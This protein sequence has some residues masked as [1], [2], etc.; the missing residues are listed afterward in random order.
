MET[1]WNAYLLLPCS[2]PLA[3]APTHYQQ[4]KVFKL[5]YKASMIRHPLTSPTSCLITPW[6]KLHYPVTV[7][8]SF[9]FVIYHVI[10]HF[11]FFAHSLLWLKCPFSFYTIFSTYF[12]GLLKDLFDP[13]QSRFPSLMFFSSILYFI[14]PLT[15]IIVYVYD[16]ISPLQFSLEFE[17]FECRGYLLFI[18]I[19]TAPVLN[20]F[21]SLIIWKQNLW[22]PTSLI[23]FAMILD[24]FPW[25][26]HSW[27]LLPF[28]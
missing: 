11:N 12:G 8:A 21:I 1:F 19:S 20:E 9:F 24:F 22:P 10:I 7:N 5:E 26:Q 6:L 17:L 2:K 16:H 25:T 15:H 28:T 27:G 3:P 14:F 13:T 23:F 4:E 18:A